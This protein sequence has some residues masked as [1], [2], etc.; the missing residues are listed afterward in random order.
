MSDEHGFVLAGDGWVQLTPLG[1]FY[2]NGAGVTQVV[3]REACDAIAKDFDARKADANF[4]GVLVD[5][6]HFSLDTDKS[7]EAAG[8]ITG[9][10][11]LESRPDGLWAKVRWSDAGL[12]AVKGGRFRL[13]SPVFPGVDS[14]EDL[15]GG[16]IRPRSL[17]SVALTNEP[18]IKGSKPI[19]NRGPS[20]GESALASVPSPVSDGMPAVSDSRGPARL[21]DHDPAD[22]DKRFLWQL[23]NPPG[24]GAHCSDCLARNGLVKTLKEWHAMP[25]PKCHC[26]CTLAEVDA[27]AP[28]A[29]DPA[30]ADG[31]SFADFGALANK[32]WT[33]EARAASLAVRRA[34][35]KPKDAQTAVGQN[36]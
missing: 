20:G 21:N 18:N 9:L 17:V 6:D 1:E 10:D 33:D 27:A 19:A 14:C 31:G 2:H 23:G 16:R 7:S 29:S 30:T 15:G 34:K 22:A 12:S 24:G 32:G 36:C 5:F 8:W 28:A 25:R 13:V 35:A 11:G 4:P 3:D 26:C